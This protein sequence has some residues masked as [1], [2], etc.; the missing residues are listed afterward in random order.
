MIRNKLIYIL[1]LGFLFSNSV[2]AQDE[3]QLTKEVQVIK[4]Y[5]PSISDAFKITR[6]P[7]ITDTVKTVPEI[8]YVLRTK[9][10]NIGFNVDPIKP[11][12]MVGE[13]LPK[14]Y[15]S[16]VKMGVGTKTLPMLEAYVNNKRSEDFSIGAYYKFDNSFA[17]VKL[18]N[19]NREFAGY[20]DNNLRFF[21]KKFLKNSTIYGDLGL[22][23][24][25]RYFYGYNTSI[26]TSLN[27]D[28]IKQNYLSFDINGGYKSNYIDS[29]HI[30]Y[31]FAFAVGYTKDLFEHNEFSFKIK[32][33][34]N[35]IFTSEMVGVKF[36]LE[37][38]SKNQNLDSTNNFIIRLNPWLGKFGK[39]WRVKAGIDMYSDIRG[40]KT[41]SF[42]YPVGSLEYDIANHYLIPYIGVNGKLEINSF[43]KISKENP[44]VI[45]GTSL[46]NT[47]HKIILYGGVRGNFNSTTY[48]NLKLTYSL[49][50]D[51]P[52]YVNDF[53]TT[54][55]VANQFGVVYDDIKLLHYFGEFSITPSEKLMFNIQAN[56]RDYKT[57]NEAK[58][59]HKPAFNLSFSTK[60]NLQKKIIVMADI[61]AIGKRYAKLANNTINELETAID[62]NLS[63]EYRYSKSLSGFIRLNNILSENYYEW[64]NYP[65]YGFN[66][67]IGATYSF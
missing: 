30:N 53:V 22:L 49:I 32:G 62:I 67:L 66:V 34:V 18:K 15:N 48:Y 56:Y 13:P 61:L 37:N 44:F 23:S 47:D 43:N 20:S 41:R 60:Y 55:N 9:P 12:K 4:P 24:N 14:L 42:Y 59:W 57:K 3:P 36:D 65:T 27:K 63:G 10:M 51:L 1:V 17:K 39:K 33:D 11:A 6:L 16:Y 25:T 2:K 8:R 38:Y 26:D 5:E 58:A 29:S 45:P 52:L 50:D 64:N 31:D 7:K 40:D 35:K 21:G 46:I 54:H 28:D 19:D